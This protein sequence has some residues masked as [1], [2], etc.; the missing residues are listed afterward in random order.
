MQ[1][2]Q[3]RIVGYIRLAAP[4]QIEGPG[5]RA[6]PQMVRLRDWAH[7]QASEIADVYVDD[8]VGQPALDRLLHNVWTGDMDV[9]VCTALDRLPHAYSALLALW[10]E[11]GQAGV[12]LVVLDERID[13]RSGTQR[14]MAEVLTA[15]GAQERSERTRSATMGGDRAAAHEQRGGARWSRT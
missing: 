5:D 11:L 13:T 1:T 4:G 12:D 3:A 14:V 8:G 6:I 10:D 15:L 9:V 2:E 7:A